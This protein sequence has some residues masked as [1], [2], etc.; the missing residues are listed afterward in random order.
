MR[1]GDWPT[2]YLDFAD[3]K[4]LLQERQGCQKVRKSGRGGDYI[5]VHNLLP[6]VEIGLNGLP[7][8]FWGD[9]NPLPLCPPVPTSLKESK[10]ACLVVSPI[11]LALKPMIW[12]L[13]LYSSFFLVLQKS[14][15]IFS[16]DFDSE[17]R[18][19]KIQWW[20]KKW[21]SSK[22]LKSYFAVSYG[23]SY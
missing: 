3:G 13:L 22:A 10:R 7:N 21:K 19:L 15:V 18:F 6:M 2:S 8:F 14:P 5:G 20:G 17:T 11:H 16:K 9:V 23:L 1:D 4:S 12:R